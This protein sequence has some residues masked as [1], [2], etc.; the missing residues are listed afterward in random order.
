MAKYTLE[1]YATAIQRLDSLRATFGALDREAAA[2][3]RHESAPTVA[4]MMPKRGRSPATSANSTP[5]RSATTTERASSIPGSIARSG[6]D[7]AM[8]CHTSDGGDISTKDS[9]RT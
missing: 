2:L 5:S 4:R 6:T 1:E 8:N 3:E 9:A 7:S